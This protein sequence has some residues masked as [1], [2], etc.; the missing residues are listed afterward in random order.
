MT[1]LKLTRMSSRNLCSEGHE[2]HRVLFSDLK[3]RVGSNYASGGWC[4]E[5]NCQFR[6]SDFVHHCDE[7]EYDLCTPCM[8]LRHTHNRVSTHVPRCQKRHELYRTSFLE[9]RSRFGSLHNSGGW[10]NR[11]NVVF[12]DEDVV[13]HCE[14]CNYDLCQEC[15]SGHTFRIKCPEG[16]ELFTKSFS[17]VRARPGSEYQSGGF[18]DNCGCSFHDDD[19]F[20][21]CESCSFDLCQQCRKMQRESDTPSPTET[22]QSCDSTDKPLQCTACCCRPISAVFLPCGH[23][24]MCRECSVKWFRM[25]Y[26]CPICRTYSTSVSNLYI[27]V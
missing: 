15:A 23:A 11:C 12:R 2:L 26:G 7:C 9:L 4:N 13:Y 1:T 17:E 6:D 19:V 18:C 20:F 5:C 16:H 24:C 22:P 3:K 27:A 21:H 25:N 10:C 14:K 8:R